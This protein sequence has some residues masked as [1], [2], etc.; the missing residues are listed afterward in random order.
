MLMPYS[1]PAITY[2][3]PQ[4]GVPGCG[5]QFFYKQPFLAQPYMGYPLPP[6]PMPPYIQRLS[7][8]TGNIASG[9]ST[10]TGVFESAQGVSH[11]YPRSWR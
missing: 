7:A 5:V 4:S 6:Q 8:A 9:N 10:L 2:Y 1:V 3:P 11:L